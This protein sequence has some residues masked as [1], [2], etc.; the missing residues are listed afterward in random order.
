MAGQSQPIYY[1]PAAGGFGQPPTAGC[2]VY[3]F[4][5]GTFYEESNRVN[6]PGTGTSGNFIPSLYF[7]AN[8][9]NDLAIDPD[10]LQIP[11]KTINRPESPA[12]SATITA[13]RRT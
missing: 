6:G 9:K 3:A 7:A 2:N 5:S 4:G 8:D 10:D 13:L 1:P 12:G 11:I